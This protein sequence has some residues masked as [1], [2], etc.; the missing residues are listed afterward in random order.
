MVHRI[1][2]PEPRDIL[3]PL[4]ACLPT[5]FLSPQPPP[6]LLPLLSPILRQRVHL[7][8]STS[9]Q[10]QQPPSQLSPSQTSDP[11]TPYP[12]QQSTWLTLLVYPPH[13]RT[14]LLE[15]VS[16]LNLEP[17]PV[18]G[19]LE[20]ETEPL[21]YSKR[22]EET[23][24]SRCDVTDLRLRVVWC[25]CT[26]D[27]GG[28]GI[29]ALT[30]AF[31]G[32]QAGQEEQKETKDGWLVHEVV[33]LD[34]EG[35]EVCDDDA[36]SQR[37]EERWFSSVADAEEAYKQFGLDEQQ[38][39]TPKTANGSGTAKGAEESDDDDYWAQYDRTPGRTPSGKNSPGRAPSSGRTQQSGLQPLTSVDSDARAQP[40]KQQQQQPPPTSSE[41]ASENAY[42][43]RYEDVQPAL[44]GHDPDEEEGAKMLEAT[45]PAARDPG[46][47]SRKPEL[48]QLQPQ[49]T[50]GQSIPLHEPAPRT[51]IRGSIAEAAQRV[52]DGHQDQDAEP[53][54]VPQ[55]HVAV[56]GKE[57]SATSEAAELGV[58]QHISSE[59]KSL[60]RLAR[61]AGIDRAEFE[62]V[63]SREVEVLGL[64][65]E[66]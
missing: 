16:K 13:S 37:G 56:T 6:A 10:Q 50:Q 2:T 18:S 58:K 62:R 59:I 20:I 32:A 19:E 51:A 27:K 40:P 21:R 43:A 54:F 41:T 60:F 64:M 24:L 26:G 53:Q 25:W 36:I 47:R 38:V 63:I 1:P 23:L 15:T 28:T 45:M 39:R 44:D 46:S 5:A 49:H 55:G 14:A 8:S 66:M 11:A 17:H 57:A 33:P 35:A 30:A 4:L 52:F 29:E 65:D 42:Y 31:G 9:A 12:R 34:E 22:D 3:L 61:S 48:P 7:L